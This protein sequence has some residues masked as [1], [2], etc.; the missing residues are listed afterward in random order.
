MSTSNYPTSE[1]DNTPPRKNPKNLIIVLLAVGLVASLVY[2]LVSQNNTSQVIEQNH[3]QIAKISDDKSA[4]QKS[5]DESLVRLDSMSGITNGMRSKLKTE[6]A[7]IAIKKAEIRRIL[8]DRNASAAELAKAKELISQLNDKIG[9]MEQ[10]VARLT[11]DNQSLSQ[12]TATLKQENTSLT[13]DLQTTTVAKQD[14]EKKV[15]IAST[16]NASNIAITPVDVKSSGKEKI[17]S[18][19]KRV[20]KLLISFQVTNRIAQSG[21][22]DI[23]VC[24]TGPDGKNMIA[25]AAGSGTFTTR[26]EGDKSYTAKVPVDFEMSQKKDVQFAFAP[27]SNFQQGSYTIRIYQN[28]YKI[29]EGTRELKKGGLFS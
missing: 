20:N 21:M 15:D 29:G 11:Q 7:Q 2:L 24:I 19:A 25:P 13:S 10:D 22:T 14:L 3:T 28:G 5:F 16:L 23:Y 1:I 12:D 27:G 4:I 26:E 17:T 8:N 6:N 9:T 18:T